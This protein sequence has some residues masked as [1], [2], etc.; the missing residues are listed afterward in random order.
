MK[1]SDVGPFGWAAYVRGSLAFR[2]YA[3]QF[4]KRGDL[5]YLASLRCDCAVT[6]AVRGGVSDHPG[7][8]AGLKT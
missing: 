7:I 3:G 8:P 4:L 1:L 2:D 6:S 5:S